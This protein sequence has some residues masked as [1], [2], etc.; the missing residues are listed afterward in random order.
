MLTLFLSHPDM[1]CLGIHQGQAYSDLPFMVQS[2]EYFF[3]NKV[4]V[5]PSIKSNNV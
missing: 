3:F 1:C 2:D 4:K 5:V